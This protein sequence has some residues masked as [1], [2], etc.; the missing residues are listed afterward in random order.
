MIESEARC[1]TCCVARS[2]RSSTSLHVNRAVFCIGRWPGKSKGRHSITA[3]QCTERRSDACKLPVLIL[4][5]YSATVPYM[6][7]HCRFT[8]NK[9]L[10]VNM[11]AVAWG[12]SV[13]LYFIAHQH[14]FTDYCSAQSALSVKKLWLQVRYDYDMTTTILRRVWHKCRTSVMRHSYNKMAVN[15]NFTKIRLMR[16]YWQFAKKASVTAKES[17][18]S[19]TV[20]ISAVIAA[21][22]K[23][24]LSKRRTQRSYGLTC[25]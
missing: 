15:I 9:T 1:G 23:K 12:L 21:C 24:K 7:T 2:W 25:R 13:S 6:S 17:L 14:F 20:A 5:M 8:C 16:L 10:A 4:S 19:T 11:L 18:L 22:V 3:G